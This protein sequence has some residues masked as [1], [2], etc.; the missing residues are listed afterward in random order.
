M[1]WKHINSEQWTMKT[2]VYLH[3]FK[4]NVAFYLHVLQWNIIS[5]RFFWWLLSLII[6]SIE[7]KFNIKIIKTEKLSRCMLQA[8][9]QRKKE[10]RTI[11]MDIFDESAFHV[12]RWY[13][14]ICQC[15]WTNIPTALIFRKIN[16]TTFYVWQVCTAEHWI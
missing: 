15:N 13:Y 2:H 11:F 10:V 3:R 4:E 7:D 9:E 1:L 12:N 14:F 5:N 16:I 6:I 8:M